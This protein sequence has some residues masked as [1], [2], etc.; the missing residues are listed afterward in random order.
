MLPRAVD[1]AGVAEL[2]A[3]WRTRLLFAWDLADGW[4]T[5]GSHR[6]L[7]SAL[8]RIGLPSNLDAV[9]TGPA[10]TAAVKT[11][12]YISLVTAGGPGPGRSFTGC[13]PSSQLLPIASRI[14]VTSCRLVSSLLPPTL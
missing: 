13:T 1:S 12:G 3:T 7:L 10:F 4:A 9:R 5:A 8:S 11:T 6:G 2:E 14:F